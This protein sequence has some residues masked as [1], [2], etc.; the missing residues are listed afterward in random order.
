MCQGYDQVAK[1]PSTID[2][3]DSGAKTASA[4]V[5]YARPHR[6]SAENDY[7]PFRVRLPRRYTRIG[8]PETAVGFQADVSDEPNP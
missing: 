2:L 7:S 6:L 1:F 4:V 5:A 3:A 8:T